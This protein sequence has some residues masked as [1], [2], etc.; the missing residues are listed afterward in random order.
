MRTLPYGINSLN[1]IQKRKLYFL[2]VRIFQG[3][4]GEQPLISLFFKFH[5]GHGSPH[6]A[7]TNHQLVD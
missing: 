2:P 3:K 1:E 6:I 5:H 7:L 4:F